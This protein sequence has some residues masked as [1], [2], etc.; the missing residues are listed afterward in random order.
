[1]CA[2]YW[3]LPR[4]HPFS[5][6]TAPYTW[7]K[8]PN[9]RFKVPRTVFFN[10]FRATAHFFQW[11]KSRGTPSAEN[12][13]KSLNIHEIGVI[14]CRYTL[15]WHWRNTLNWKSWIVMKLFM[16]RWLP[17]RAPDRIGTKIRGFPTAPWQYFTAPRLKNTALENSGS[18]VA[19]FTVSLTRKKIE[20]MVDIGW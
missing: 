17:C 6:N 10:L 8:I 7:A 5:I 2:I 3:Y 11:K 1:M 14:L 13:G 12:V 9:P 19:K 20:W 15:S 4:F 18:G 16:I